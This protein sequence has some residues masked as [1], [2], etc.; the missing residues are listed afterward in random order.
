MARPISAKEVTE[1]APS[2]PSLDTVYSWMAKG[3]KTKNGTVKLEHQ[4]SGI[5][6]FTTEE[7]L[8]AF[9][10]KLTEAG[11]PCRRRPAKAE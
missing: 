10:G 9:L 2:H 4:R 6:L 1:L 5:R 3:I 11:I 7:L 8:A